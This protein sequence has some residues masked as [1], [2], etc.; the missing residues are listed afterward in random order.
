MLKEENVLYAPYV[1]TQVKGSRSIDG[2]LLLHTG[3]LPINYGAYSA[4]FPHHTYYSIDK[5]FLKE[6]MEGGGTCCMTVDKKVVWNVA[7]VA[8]DFDL[9]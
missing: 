6:N 8:Q 5:S 3:L 7:I 1:Q 9:R 4:R 2:Q